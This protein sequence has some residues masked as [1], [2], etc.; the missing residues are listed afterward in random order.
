MPEKLKT[1]LGAA[2]LSLKKIEWWVKAIG[3][4]AVVATI[5]SAW[6]SVKV[7]NL[8]KLEAE[9]K[10]RVSYSFRLAPLVLPN[11]QQFY[12]RSKIRNL[13]TRELTYLMIGIRVWPADKW[14]DTISVTTNR[15]DVIVA[16]NLV[17]K[18][19]KSLC[20]EPQDVASENAVLM[21]KR[22]GRLRLRNLPG[23]LT[24]EATEQD[25]EL[26][27]GPYP[28]TKEQL[29][30]GI[31]LEGWAYVSETDDGDCVVYAEKAPAPGALPYLCEKRT[32]GEANCLE[33]AQCSYVSSPQTFFSKAALMTSSMETVDSFLRH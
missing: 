19:P 12:V 25:A 28:I 10:R 16:D 1:Q 13:S 30:Q 11:S 24:V 6:T 32:N 3:I 26:V 21:M 27:F 23:N 18:C 33:T 22:S 4:V 20:E 5:A 2:D 7:S 14:T 9:E 29:E 31:W 8:Q 17:T 15:D